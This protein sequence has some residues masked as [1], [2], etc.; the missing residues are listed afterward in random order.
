[1]VAPL[2]KVADL[3]SQSNSKSYFY[4]FEYQSKVSDY[5]QV[6]TSFQCTFHLIS[7]V[8]PTLR[9]IPY[10]WGQ[11][12]V[13]FWTTNTQLTVPGWLTD[14]PSVQLPKFLEISVRPIKLILQSRVIMAQPYTTEGW[15]K[16]IRSDRGTT[17]RN[18]NFSMLINN[19]VWPGNAIGIDINPCKEKL[20]IERNHEWM[21]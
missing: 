15:Q 5:A 19:K 3:H 12:K 1:M 2:V 17:L 16:K 20:I 6:R 9:L 4:V 21:H 7:C 13:P 11:L 10:W 8:Q 14:P 18:T